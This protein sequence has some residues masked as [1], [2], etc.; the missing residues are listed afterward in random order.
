VPFPVDL[1][2]VRIVLGRLNGKGTTSVVPL[3]TARFGGLQPLRAVWVHCLRQS[4]YL[5]RAVRVKLVAVPVE[6][7]ATFRVGKPN[8]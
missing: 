2:E 7:I 4:S 3:E 1:F 6:L 5:G 8:G